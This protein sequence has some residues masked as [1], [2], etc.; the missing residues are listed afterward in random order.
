MQRFLLSV[1]LIT[2]VTL[3]VGVTADAAEKPAPIKVLLIGGDDV[4]PYHDHHEIS[5]KTRA[6]NASGPS[7]KRRFEPL[8]L[9]LPAVVE[10]I[11]MAEAVLDLPDP[12]RRTFAGGNQIDVAWVGAESLG[13]ETRDR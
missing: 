13:H 6:N 8:V 1:A 9:D 4:A 2:V 7:L 11:D 3:S 12:L 10:S 5:E